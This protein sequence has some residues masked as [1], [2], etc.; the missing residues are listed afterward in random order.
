MGIFQKSFDKLLH[1][2]ISEEK[3]GALFF[4]RQLAK[5]DVVPSDEQMAE[6]ESRFVKARQQA[7][8]KEGEVGIEIGDLIPEGLDEGLISSELENSEELETF[9][10]ELTANLSKAMPQ[11]YEK[12]ADT[13]TRTL[14]RNAPEMLDR[15]RQE[16]REYEERMLEKWGGAIDLL[17][18]LIV[19]STEAGGLFN[20]ELRPEAA[21]EGDLV[22]DVLTRLH[23]RACQVAQEVLA[24]LK[25]GFADGAHA[26]WRTLHEITIVATFIS[27]NDNDTA[28][29]YVLHNDIESY[30]AA[31]QQVEHAQR[32]GIEE[33]D[34]LAI[35]HLKGIYDRLIGQFGA[36]YR[37]E[38]GWAAVALGNARPNFS[39]IEKAVSFQHMRPYYKLASHN[40]HANAKGM[41]FKLGLFSNRDE[42]L[43]V[44]SSDMGLADPGQS[45]ALSLAQL[46][47]AMLT[48]QPNIDTV[49]SSQVI[50]GFARDCQDAFMSA[51]WKLEKGRT[52]EK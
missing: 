34:D 30:K 5:Y 12:T 22:F 49:V 51:H 31:K 40:V 46:T 42:I 2:N 27:E 47:I 26:R 44:G 11:I 6:I 4:K 7:G 38:Y 9:I 15:L 16:R 45:T 23:A 17:E 28:N 52:E 36:D 29:R 48:S 18:T 10:E 37:H 20:D 24:L 32:L 39:D 43:L 25:C 50:L 3:I 35:E 13:L 41:F 19:I 21:R 33:P 1:E 14:K 8:D